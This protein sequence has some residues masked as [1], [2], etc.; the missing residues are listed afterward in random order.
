MR[1]PIAKVSGPEL[2]E[3]LSEVV[4]DELNAKVYESAETVAIDTN[5]T[6]EL[7]S[8]GAVRELMRA[9]QGR[10]KSEGLAPQDSVVL[11]VDTSDEGKSAINSHIDLIT[12]TVGANSI[13]F[14]EVEGEPV[15]AGDLTFKFQIKVI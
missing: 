6:P 7:I 14:A 5:L 2:S 3:E 11:T 15:K 10:R 8:E 13:E 9:V 1:Q 12:K 4:L